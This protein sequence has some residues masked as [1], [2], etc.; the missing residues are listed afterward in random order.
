M[1]KGSELDIRHFMGN[2]LALFRHV[3]TEAKE[4]GLLPANLD[5]NKIRPIQSPF[6]KWDFRAGRRTQGVI[7]VRSEFAYSPEA[8]ARVVRHELYH[9][10]HPLS[11][12]SAH[13][14]I[15]LFWFVMSLPLRYVITEIAARL[16]ENTRLK[17]R[18]SPSSDSNRS[19]LD[20]E[21]R[22]GFGWRGRKRPEQPRPY[23]INPLFRNLQTTAR[24]G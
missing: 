2:R 5:S 9:E 22:N 1:K 6:F 18:R 11:T 3:L 24:S 15:L 7:Y 13:E 4:S 17:P 14:P 10:L 8:L 23:L 20:M 16:A 19:S 12:P 21:V